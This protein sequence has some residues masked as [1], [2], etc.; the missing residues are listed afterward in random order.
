M[1]Q[2]KAKAIRESIPLWRGC[3]YQ[4]GKPNLMKLPDGV[5]KGGKPKFRM[6]QYASTITLAKECGRAIYK[7][8]KQA[9]E[10]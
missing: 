9:K 6:F 4:E 3:L 7:A 10:V 8:K 1:N 2:K 5:D